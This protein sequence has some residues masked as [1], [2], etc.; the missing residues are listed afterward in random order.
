M[1]EWILCPW[2]RAISNKLRNDQNVFKNNII[3]LPSSSRSSN[4]DSFKYRVG[5]LII[6]WNCSIHVIIKYNMFSF[7]N[8]PKSKSSTM[9][10][11]RT[12]S[13][14]LRWEPPEEGLWG[15][16]GEPW[17]RLPA[18]SRATWPWSTAVEPPLVPPLGLSTIQMRIVPRGTMRIRMIQILW[19]KSLQKYHQQIL[20]YAFVHWWMNW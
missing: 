16:R 11:L 18:G 10:T 1:Q 4:T 7:Q 12:V 14:H 13:P 20:R 19:L 17:S 8:K 3:L 9:E 2:Q 6:S 15:P 5:N